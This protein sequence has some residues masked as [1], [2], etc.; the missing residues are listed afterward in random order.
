MKVSSMPQNVLLMTAE[1]SKISTVNYVDSVTM[2]D[3]IFRCFSSEAGSITTAQDHT[4]TNNLIRKIVHIWFPGPTP[5]NMELSNLI[6]RDLRN[7][8]RLLMDQIEAVSSFV[9]VLHNEGIL[10]L[11]HNEDA[12][13]LT[14]RE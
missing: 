5:V 2:D 3:W 11:N 9:G 6:G 4:I 14:V 1:S 13:S 7:K 12:L 8:T 10:Y